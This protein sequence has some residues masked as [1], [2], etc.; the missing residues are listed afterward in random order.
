VV[1]VVDVAG[2]PRRAEQAAADSTNAAATTI[3]PT[4][5]DDL[6]VTTSS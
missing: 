3:E 6:T 5:C 2:G 1:L 4:R